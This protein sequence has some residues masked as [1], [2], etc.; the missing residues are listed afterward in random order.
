VV[1]LRWRG[2]LPVMANRR[3]ASDFANRRNGCGE[4]VLLL[5]PGGGATI[6]RIAAHLGV[7]R[8]TVSRQLASRGTSFSSILD[9]SELS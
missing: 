3:R 6:K 8:R 9:S 4:L 5:L 1:C 2:S 7:D